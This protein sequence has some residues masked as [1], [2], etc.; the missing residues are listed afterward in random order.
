MLLK[1]QVHNW[2]LPFLQIDNIKIG[3][4]DLKSHKMAAYY[5]LV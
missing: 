4:D 2:R 5:L 1:P 3:A